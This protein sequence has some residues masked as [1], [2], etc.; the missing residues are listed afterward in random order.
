MVWPLRLEANTIVSPLLAFLIASR[1]DPAPL[2][3]ALVT[4]SVLGTVRS[5]RISRRGRNERRCGAGRWCARERR[6]TR[7]FSDRSS[8]SSSE[9]NHIVV[10]PVRGVG[11]RYN[12]K[13]ITPSAQTERRGQAGPVRGLLGSPADFFI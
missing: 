13:A 8:E 9:G 4:V 11:L 10:S 6:P 3:W 1:S 2:S 12:G 7:G 5:S